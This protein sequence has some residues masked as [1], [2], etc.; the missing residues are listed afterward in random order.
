MKKSSK[1]IKAALSAL[2]V[3]TWGAVLYSLFP[4][5]S[6]DEASTQLTTASALD[7]PAP[8]PRLPFESE[9]PNPF[10]V[11]ENLMVVKKPVLAVT[12]PTQTVKPPPNPRSN[13]S[14]KRPP[15]PRP[16]LHELVG[17]T[18]ELA[19]FR[20]PD[21]TISILQMGDS[22]SGYVIKGIQKEAV[23]LGHNDSDTTLYV[24]HPLQQLTLN[25]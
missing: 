20:A 2:V 9:A 4:N 8:P 3:I 19:L 16:A 13:P 6:P 1:K 21:T 25:Q 18:G 12:V 23:H 22:L 7:I 15:K 10:A 11:P 24:N 14:K 5:T 17:I